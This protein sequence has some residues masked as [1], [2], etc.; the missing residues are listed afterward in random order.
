MERIYAAY[1]G[2]YIFAA[3]MW[4]RVGWRETDSLTIWTGALIYFASIL[5][6]VAGR[7]TYGEDRINRC[8]SQDKE[9]SW[10]KSTVA[11]SQPIPS[12]RK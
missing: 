7:G 2:V 8:R 6:I 11:S 1:G 5:I 10:Q 4:L 9:K 12:N 3:L